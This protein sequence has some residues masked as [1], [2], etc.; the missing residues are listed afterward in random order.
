MCGM[1]I[2]RRSFKNDRSVVRFLDYDVL[3]AT[4]SISHIL[5]EDWRILVV[6]IFGPVAQS[7]FLCPN[8][9]AEVNA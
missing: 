9:K 5:Y 7:T 1:Y 6:Y 4:L 8:R 3:L 2:S